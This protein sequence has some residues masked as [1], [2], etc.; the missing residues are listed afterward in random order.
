LRF[1]FTATL[2]Q[3]DAARHLTFV[4]EPRNAFFNGIFVGPIEFSRRQIGSNSQRETR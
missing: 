1:F 3:A 4:H 2:G